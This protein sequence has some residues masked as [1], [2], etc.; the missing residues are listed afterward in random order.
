MDYYLLYLKRLISI[1][2]EKK[3]VIFRIFT[4][5][6]QLAMLIADLGLSSICLVMTVERLFNVVLDLDDDLLHTSNM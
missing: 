6:K 1:G 2:N 5:F 3:D 4:S